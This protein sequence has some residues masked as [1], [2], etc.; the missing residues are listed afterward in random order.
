MNRKSKM[1]QEQII[2]LFTAG[3]SIENIAEK[4]SIHR[5]T[6][7]GYVKAHGFKVKR[8][9]P[10]K[11]GIFT[12]RVPA[13]S[14]AKPTIS[15][16]GCPPGLESKPPGPLPSQSQCEPHREFI[17]QRLLRGMDAF[18]IWYDLKQELGFK[19]GYDSVKRFV[20]KIKAKTPEV[21][22]VIPTLPG[23]EA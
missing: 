9:R 8:G 3:D 14:D 13:G 17:A 20:R 10:S 5:D 22:A 12:C 2:A 15:L 4:L 16:S 7:S 1:Q 6:V 23:Q 11:T 19:A 21:F 18:Y